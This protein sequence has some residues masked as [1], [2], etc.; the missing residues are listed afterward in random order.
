MYGEIN[1]NNLPPEV[2]FQVFLQLMEEGFKDPVL[3][4]YLL[5]LELI[6]KALPIYFRYLQPQQ[7]QNDLI[8]TVKMILTKTSDLKSKVRE[9]SINFCLYLSHQSPIGPATM[10]KEV[11]NELTSVQSENAN[12]PK[13][14][15]ANAGRN[16]SPTKN[17]SKANEKP[18]TAG[19]TNLQVST[20]FGNSHLIA[21]CIMLLTQFQQQAGLIN[22]M[23]SQFFVDYMMNIN[24]ALRHS[25]P[26]VRKQA[27]NLFKILYA[28]FGDELIP[29][30]IDQ[31]PAL[32]QKLIKEAKVEASQAK[33]DSAI[34]YNNANQTSAPIGLQKPKEDENMLQRKTT[35]QLKEGFLEMAPIK[36]LLAGNEDLITQLKLP[37]PKKRLKAI[38]EIKKVVQRKFATLSSAQARDL[39]EPLQLL[40]RELLKD[41]S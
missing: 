38:V 41:D 14:P 18:T 23:T 11:L 8:P 39:L 19:G 9:A 17:S 16:R 32:Q 35:M 25:N 1:H 10:I 13:T 30:L 15:H 26:Q 2:S 4:N 28:S 7:I 5:I 3:K 22:S 31:K 24:K 40:V 27:E 21:S 34:G 33:P 6:Q 29:K 37:N 20:T 36:E 12:A